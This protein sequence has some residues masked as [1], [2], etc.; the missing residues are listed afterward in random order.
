[1]T[2]PLD[3]LA[4]RHGIS[5]YFHEIDGTYHGVSDDTKRALLAA[6]GVPAAT[7]EDVAQSLQTAPPLQNVVMR[8]PGRRCFMPE[9]LADRRIWGI[10]LQLYQLRSARNWGIGDFADLEAAV[11]MAAA[12]GADFVGTNPLHAMFPAEPGRASPFFPSNRRFL[13]TLYIAVDKLPGFA[14]SMV[15]MTMLETARAGDLVDYDLVARLKYDALRKVRNAWL[16]TTALPAEWSHEAFSEWYAQQG[17]GLRLHAL[18]DALS[19]A[20]HDDRLPG[21][22]GWKAWPEEYRLPESSV[23]ETFARQNPAEVEFHAWLQFAAD[24]QLA[25]AAAAC[26]KGGMRVGLY[27][28]LA[29]GEAPDGSATWADRTLAVSGAEIGAPPDYFTRDGQNWGLAG[30]SPTALKERDFAPYRA[31][32]AAVMRHAGAVRID[33]AMGVWQ[34][35]FIPIGRPAAEGTYVRFPIEDMLASIATESDRYRTIVVGEDLGN[36]PE[37]FRDVMAAAGLQSYRILYFERTDDGFRWPRDYPRDALA[38]LATHDLPTLEGWWRGADVDLRLRFGLI[39]EASASVQR[40]SRRIERSQLAGNLVQSG[41]IDQQSA[42]MV[43]SMNMD[44]DT[45]LRRDFVV[46]VHRHLAR[47]ASRLSA[48]RIEDLAAERDPVNL[49]GTVLEY[50]NWRRRLGVAIEDLSSTELFQA[51]CD[52]MRTERPKEG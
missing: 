25:D 39:D 49:P 12:A 44:S 32:M 45:P 41:L 36:V 20:M 16:D 34:L 18:H 33:H 51:V 28:D 40:E 48:I 50:P 46:A 30:L 7:D 14:P 6:F 10:A 23:V 3:E 31:L 17:E 52:A 43:L 4:E 29:V 11:R 15:D 22:M 27:L 8:A 47:A 5:L 38:C 21:R 2:T 26:K 35:F 19:L 1:M 13:N 37:G 9:A 24:R 42:D